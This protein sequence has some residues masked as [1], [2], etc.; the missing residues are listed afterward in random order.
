MLHGFRSILFKIKLLKKLFINGRMFFNQGIAVFSGLLLFEAP[1]DSLPGFLQHFRIFH[2]TS[3]KQLKNDK[4]L[5]GL[6][7]FTDFTNIH[8]VGGL[9]NQGQQ[10]LDFHVGCGVFCSCLFLINIAGCQLLKS[11]TFAALLKQLSSVLSTLE[12]QGMNQHLTR[13]LPVKF[14]NLIRVGG[15]ILHAIVD[16]FLEET[17]FFKIIK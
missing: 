17:L 5:L 4:S 9:T 7:Q 12:N 11:D 14:I 13:H 10:I 3:I 1:V 16:Q 6:K 2:K 8:V 15:Q